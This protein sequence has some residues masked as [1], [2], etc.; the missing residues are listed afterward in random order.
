MTLPQ[1]VLQSEKNVGGRGPSGPQPADIEP[2]QGPCCSKFADQR[3]LFGVVFTGA[4]T[5]PGFVVGGIGR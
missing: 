3:L 2:G 5:L 4:H 1:A